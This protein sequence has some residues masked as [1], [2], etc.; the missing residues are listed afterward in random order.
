MHSFTIESVSNACGELFPNNTLSFFYKLFT[1]AS[2]LG[3]AMG[4]CNFR[5]TLPI[6]VPNITEGK[7]TF[8]DEKLSKS[9]STDNLE[10]SLYTSIPDIVKP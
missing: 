10:P 8:F 5:R 1:R 9:T 3:G 6:N 7:I 2:K 4:G